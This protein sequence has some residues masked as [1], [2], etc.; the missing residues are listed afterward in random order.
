MKKI[1]ALVVGVLALAAALVPSLHGGAQVP[2]ITQTS[3]RFEY[4]RMMSFSVE[5]RTAGF[6][7]R[8]AGY[9]AC[10]AAATGWV[11][12]DFEIQSAADD[13]TLPLALTT[14]GNEGWELAST[15]YSP[16][17]VYGGTT[18]LFKRPKM[19]RVELR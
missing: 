11:C 9:R 8:F 14:I 15:L 2:P 16:D 18:Y 5:D 17:P 13:V 7:R 6:G 4:L 10:A 19:N 12:R 3:E 1:A